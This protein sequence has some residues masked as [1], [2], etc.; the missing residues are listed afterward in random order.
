MIIAILNGFASYLVFF[1]M[2][3]EH[4]E[5]KIREILPEEAEITQIIFDPQRSIVVIEAK[6]PGMAIGKDG[7]LL[8]EVKDITMWVPKVQRSSI[9]CDLFCPLTL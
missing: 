1:L 9:K 8:R 7:S 5:K 4:T 2:D 6:K 3:K